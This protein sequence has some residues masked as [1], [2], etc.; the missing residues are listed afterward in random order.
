MD[1]KPMSKS[2]SGSYAG[3]P[4][5]TPMPTYTSVQNTSSFTSL[6]SPINESAKIGAMDDYPTGRGGMR[7]V[8]IVLAEQSVQP[9]ARPSVPIGARPPVTK[10]PTNP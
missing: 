7:M 10:M 2:A 3:Q 6:Q 1:K 4:E 5:P 9:A 8:P